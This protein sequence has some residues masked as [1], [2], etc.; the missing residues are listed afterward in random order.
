MYTA[1]TCTIEAP[2]N[3][4]CNT[5]AAHSAHVSIGHE[6]TEP[7]PEHLM[8]GHWGGRGDRGKGRGEEGERTGVGVGVRVR[9]VKS[10]ETVSIYAVAR[11]PRVFSAPCQH[12]RVW[13]LAGPPEQNV[14][15]EKHALGLEKRS[16]ITLHYSFLCCIFDRNSISAPAP[17]WKWD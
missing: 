5:A 10:R 15:T 4:R 17:A 14:R 9:R 8:M 7:S 6:Y 11:V 16:A 13:R 1:W 12:F 3:S 2:Q